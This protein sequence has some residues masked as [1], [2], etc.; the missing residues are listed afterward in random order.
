VPRGPSLIG[1]RA[2]T[3]SINREGLTISPDVDYD[4]LLLRNGW[5]PV[6]F[7]AGASDLVSASKIYLRA[8]VAELQDAVVLAADADVAYFEELLSAL[9]GTSGVLADTVEVPLLNVPSVHEGNAGA[10]D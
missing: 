8:L 5:S 3:D 10:R 7:L 6:W 1:K 4:S 9:E 2:A